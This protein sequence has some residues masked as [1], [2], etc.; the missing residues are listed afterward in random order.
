MEINK[1]EVSARL[2][3][4]FKDS[5]N[6]TTKIR[7]G[8]IPPVGYECWDCDKVLEDLN[9]SL[10]ELQSSVISMCGYVLVICKECQKND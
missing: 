2:R 6:H 8:D 10:E 4:K 1:E 9:F 7:S 5:I 3:E